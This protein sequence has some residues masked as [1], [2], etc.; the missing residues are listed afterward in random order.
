MTDLPPTVQVHDLG[1]PSS[2]A[3]DAATL[4]LLLLEDS[5]T[6]LVLLDP[7]GRLTSGA[8]VRLAATSIYEVAGMAVVA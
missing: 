2:A 5:P 4:H 8:P 7:H 1:Q 3:T 6:T